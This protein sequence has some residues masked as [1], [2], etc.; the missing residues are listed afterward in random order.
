MLSS[1]TGPGGATGFGARGE[2]ASATPAVP[3]GGALMGEPAGADGGRVAV[4]DT[5]IAAEPRAR[6]SA[7]RS[8]TKPSGVWLRRSV[9][10][11]LAARAGRRPT[12]ECAPGRRS[13]AVPHDVA[14]AGD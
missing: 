10:G 13:R 12:A 4:S 8:T 6:R 2:H 7:P 5:R 1:P 11:D 14:D 3:E 9:A